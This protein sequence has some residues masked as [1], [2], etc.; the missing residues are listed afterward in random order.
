LAQ[1]PEIAFAAA[2][3]GPTNIF[4][5]VVCRDADALYDYLANQVG[6]LPGVLQVETAP[7]M[8]SVKRSG[9]LLIHH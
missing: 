6:A 3:T 1:H 2:V 4:A 9:T 7:I 8:R 5:F